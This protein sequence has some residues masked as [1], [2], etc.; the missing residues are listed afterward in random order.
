MNRIIEYIEDSCKNLAAN[1]SVFRYKRKMLD[2][3]AEKARELSKTG[4]KDEKVI[5]DLVADEFGNLEENFNE[6]EK[7]KKRKKLL[8]FGLPIGSIAFLI[9]LF[10]TYFIVSGVTDA[11]GKTW[12]IIVGGVFA[13]IIFLFSILIAKLCTMRRVFHPI[14][15]LLIVLS[16]ILLAV[17]SFLFLHIMVPTELY[18]WPT[19]PAGVAVALIG[20]LIFAFR[21][22]QKLRTISFFFYMPA[23][24]TML[25]VIL[26][27]NSI[28]TWSGGWIIILLGLAIDAAYIIYIIASNIK[29]FT[30]K[31]EVEE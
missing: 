14:A 1:Q 7:K 22:K 6:F 9:L 23:I 15:R 28:V 13:L 16:T 18:V 27:A 19:L 24:A 2:D 25:Y 31:Q 17:F 12:L 29:Y 20:D 5:A 26:A 8:K 21:T 10:V 3:M 4:L 11:W 30:Y